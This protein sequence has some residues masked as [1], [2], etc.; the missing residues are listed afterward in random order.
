V[1][2]RMDDLVMDGSIRARLDALHERLCANCR[3]PEGAGPATNRN[4]A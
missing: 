4:Q 3:I 1:W 2:V